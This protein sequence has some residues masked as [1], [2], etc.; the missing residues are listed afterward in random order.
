[1][2]IFDLYAGAEELGLG[3]GDGAVGEVAEAAAEAVRAEVAE[4]AVQVEEQSQ[5]IETLVEKVND[6]DDSVDELAENIEGM[7]HLLSSGSFNAQSF[8]LLYNRSCKLSSKLGGKVEDGGRMGAESFGDAATAQLMARG[9]MEGFMDTVKSWSKKAIEFIKHIFNT[10]INFFISL[11]DEAKAIQNRCDS[12]K[13]RLE[14]SKTKIKE[15]IKLGGWNAYFNYAANGLK[16]IDN[17][18]EWAKTND[19]IVALTDLAKNI[20]GLGLSEVNSAYSSLISAIKGDVKEETDKTVEKKEGSGETLIGNSNGVRIL[21]RFGDTTPKNM[22]EAAAA[23]RAVKIT[24]IK[25]GE[26][27]KLATGEATARYTA[28]Q[29]LGAVG[30]VRKGADKIRENKVSKKFTAAERDR[31]IGSLN[32]I[33]ASDGEKGEEVNGKLNVV[34]AIFAMSASVAETVEKA[35][36]NNLRAGLDCVSAHL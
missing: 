33:K 17:T 30:T 5:A 18:A 29:L 2:S 6:M 36:I 20:N 15:K 8:A 1:M 9:G 26:A 27:K 31:V 21:A 23:I 4:V 13:K 11:W 3:E 16:K 10:V 7:E 34:R 19:A 28:A 12:L 14:D 32:A 25:D 35:R 22:T 24:I